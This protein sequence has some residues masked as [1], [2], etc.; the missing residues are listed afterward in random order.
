[1]STDL[2]PQTSRTPSPW[3]GPPDTVQV[4]C[5]L[6]GVALLAGALEGVVRAGGDVAELAPRLAVYGLV[7]AVVLWFHSGHRWAHWALLLGVG[8]VGTAS[9]VVEPVLWAGSGSDVGAT[10]MGM[11]A[12]EWVA[13][14]ARVAHVAA[15]LAAVVLM[16]RPR[17]W[18]YVRAT[19]DLG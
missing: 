8:V 15:V 12:G 19:S 4:A 2:R 6:L 5:A 14:V 7:G 18:R 10:L 11:S 9:L 3:R 1:M 16:L 17:T 13:A